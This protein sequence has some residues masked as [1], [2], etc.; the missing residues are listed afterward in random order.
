M[1]M[2]AEMKGLVLSAM[3]AGYVFLVTLVYPNRAPGLPPEAQTLRDADGKT[4]RLSLLVVALL[5]LALAYGYMKLFTKLT[6]GAD[7]VI[8][9]MSLMVAISFV[10]AAAVVFATGFSKEELAEMEA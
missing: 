6:A 7:F 5:S 4:R 8:L 1:D 10:I 3:Y 9:T 2:F